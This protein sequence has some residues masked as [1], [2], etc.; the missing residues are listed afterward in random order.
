M[1]RGHRPSRALTATALA[2]LGVAGLA[3]GALAQDST[4]RITMGSPGDAGIAV[5]EAIGDQFEAEH[6]G[7]IVEFDFQDDDLYQTIGLPQALASRNAPD[8]YFEW[9]GARMEQRAADG[10]AADLTDAVASGPLAGIVGEGTLPSASVDGKVVLLPHT[11]DITN[12]IWYN[13]PLLEEHGVTPPTTWEELLAACDTLN[14]AGITPISS[15]NKDLWAAGNWLSHLASRVVG[16]ATPCSSRSGTLYQSRLLTSAVCGKSTTLP[17][18]DAEGR[19]PSPTMPAS[20]PEA[21]ASER[22][23]A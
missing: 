22:S 7:V 11:A 10:Y 14:A 20:G 1:Q 16:G 18:T 9:T 2:A 23:A 6:P 8:I 3:G 19:V 5:W 15:G 4:L 17:S 13:V 21:T 12:V